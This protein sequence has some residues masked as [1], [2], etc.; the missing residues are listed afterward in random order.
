[1]LTENSGLLLLCLF[2]ILTQVQISQGHSMAEG[3]GASRVH[4]V[5]LPCQS[6]FRVLSGWVFSVSKTPQSLPA[7]HVWDRQS[8]WPPSESKSSF[9]HLTL[10]SSS[11]WTACGSP[12][13]LSCSFEAKDNTFFQSSGVIPHCHELSK[14]TR[15][16]LATTR[17]SFLSSFGSI[18]SGPCPYLVKCS[19]TWSSS[20]KNQSFLLWIFWISQSSGVPGLILAVKTDVKKVFN[21]SVFSVF[22]LLF[23]VLLCN[24]L[25]HLCLELLPE[26]N[27]VKVSIYTSAFSGQNR[28]FTFPLRKELKRGGLLW[29]L[30][31]PNAPVSSFF[32]TRRLEDGPG[33]NYWQ[34]L[35]QIICYM[36][37]SKLH[38]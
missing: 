36:L 6:R 27:R 17:A 4:L 20:N 32:S 7:A 31:L 25:P 37:V 23:L 15:N 28:S 24:K 33:N 12:D 21:V 3:G 9:L 8:V 30:D 10:W 1:M 5:Q 16:D 18:P 34:V 29:H 2:R 13:P 22:L 38:S 11:G 14:K 26:N 35:E 19:L